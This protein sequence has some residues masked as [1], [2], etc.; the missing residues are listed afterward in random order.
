MSVFDNGDVMAYR[1]LGGGWSAGVPVYDGGSSKLVAQGGFRPRSTQFGDLTP[2]DRRDRQ[3]LRQRRRPGLP[4][5][6]RQLGHH[7]PHVRRRILPTRRHRPVPA[8]LNPVHRPRRRPTRR[9]VSIADN[10]DVMA[11]RNLGGGWSAAL[12]VYDG[13]S[14][15]LVAQGGSGRRRA[16][17]RPRRRRLA[18]RD[19]QR[20]RQRRRPGLPQPQRQLGHQLPHVRRRILPTRRHRRLQTLTT[21]RAAA[22]PECPSPSGPAHRRHQ[23]RPASSQAGSALQTA[24]LPS[25]LPNS[26]LGSIKGAG[27][28]GARRPAGGATGARPRPCPRF[29]G[30]RAAESSSRVSMLW[31]ADLDPLGSQTAGRHCYARRGPP[32]GVGLCCW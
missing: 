29:T 4:Q 1:N 27:R 26:A 15:K 7:L 23:G 17:R 20:L 5:P 22:G 13:G 18:P 28:A 11:Y 24:T 3:R 8:H 31:V 6:Q 16:D 14:S 2:T 10:G 9:I 12:P 19:R 25:A 21:Q 30:R 32:A